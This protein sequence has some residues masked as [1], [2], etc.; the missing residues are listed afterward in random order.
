LKSRLMMPTITHTVATEG[1]PKRALEVLQR[2]LAE[3]PRY[4]SAREQLGQGLHPRIDPETFRRLPFITKQD[5]RQSFPHGFLPK[6]VELEALLEMDL[7]ELEHTSGTSES[8]T[9]LILGKGWWALQEEWALRLNRHV[10]L[11]LDEFPEAR[12]VTI[13]SPFCSGDICYKGVPSREE[14][15]VGQSLYVNLSR[16][17]FLWS[18]ADLDRML[19]ETIEWQPQFLDVDPVYG[20]LFA[21]HCER[22]GVRLASLQ[23]IVASYEYVS[24]LHRRIMDRAFGVPVHVLYGSTETGHL[25]METERDCLAPSLQTAYFETL[26]PDED[27]ISE[28]CVTTL[29]NQ[30]MP[31]VRYRIG[32]LVEAP[33]PVTS[34]GWRLHGRAGDAFRAPEGQRVTVRQVDECFRDLEGFIHYQLAETEPGRLHLRYVADYE[35]PT[36]QTLHELRSRLVRLLEPSRELTLQAVD[37]LLSEASGKFRL[38]Y[39]AALA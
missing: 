24:L 12:R 22:R 3:T 26:A 31:L 35:P 2:T 10:A 37:S 17:P 18:E 21:R 27:G 13:N 14:R 28:L 19:A 36:S 30:Y 39:P 32:D 7:V 20:L 8:R 33:D 1:L 4:A 15:A 29:T 6:G 11:T 34:V 38:G 16:H 9:P 5:I 23:F 25:L